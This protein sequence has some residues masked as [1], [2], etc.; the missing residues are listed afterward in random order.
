MS[1]TSSLTRV[2]KTMGRLPSPSASAVDLVD[3]LV[4]L[5]D[6]VDEG[7]AHVARLGRELREDGVAEGLGGD[8]GAVGDEEHGAFGHGGGARLGADRGNGIG[9]S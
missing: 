2:M 8:A 6:R 4:R 1:R 3:H 9:P 5:V 7:P